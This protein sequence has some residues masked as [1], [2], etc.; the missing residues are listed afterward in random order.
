L[1]TFFVNNN[2]LEIS[3]KNKKLETQL[4]VPKEIVKSFGQFAVKINQRLKELSDADN[5]SIIRTIPAANCHELKGSSKWKLAVDVSR[6]YRMIFEP[7]HSPIPKKDDGGLNWEETT[8]IQIN[9]IV[10]YH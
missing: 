2:L 5:L 3:F 1:L 9:E 4:T 6:N 7:N 8:K 10:D